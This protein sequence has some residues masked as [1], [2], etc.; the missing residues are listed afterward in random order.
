VFCDISKAFDRVWLRGLLHKL[1]SIGINGSLLNWFTSYLSDRKQRVVY[2]NYSSNWSSINVGVPQGSILG[3]L[4]FLININYIVNDVN[5]SI[6]LFADDTSLYIIVENPIDA[7][8]HL[9]DDLQKNHEWSK[10]WLVTF[11]PSK[12][13][14]M[15]FSRK[16]KQVN[17]PPIQMNGIPIKRVQSHTHLGVTLSENVKWDTHLSIILRKA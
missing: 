4:L 3:P 9:N 12:T 13:E 11:N 5:S 2:A 17:H 6:R 15:I 14:S 8:K 1:T 7:A 16:I 10:A